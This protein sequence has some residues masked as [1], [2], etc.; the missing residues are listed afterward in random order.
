MSIDYKKI[1]EL[2]LGTPLDTDVIP[3]VDLVEGKTKKATKAELKGDKGDQGDQGI[4][5]VQGIQGIQGVKGDIGITWQGAWSAGTYQINDGVSHNGSS[6]IATSITTEEPSLSATDWDLV[7]QRGDDGTGTGDVSSNTASSVDGEIALFSGVTG[8]EIKRAT[9]SGVATIT[10]GVLGTKTNP[11]GAFV[12]TTDTQTLEN[13]TLTS[14][15]INT[16][17]GIVKGDVGLGNVDNTSDATKNSATAT[18]TNKTITDS[19]NNVTANGLRTATTTVSVSGATAPTAGQVLTATNGT[20]ATWQTPSGGGGEKMR[21][22]HSTTQSGETSATKMA[23]DT[24]SYDTGNNFAS[25]TYTVPTSGYYRINVR[26]NFE[27]STSTAN[28]QYT[29]ELRVNNTPVAVGYTIISATSR[30]STIGINELLNLTAT[31][32]VDVYYFGGNVNF[33]ILGGAT[34]TMLQI[35]QE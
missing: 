3:Y 8:K 24:E 9:G 35:S 28:I 34:Q 33:T 25:N 2:E 21:A 26:A 4:Q 30:S 15:V 7:A 13:K 16:P 31:D 29:L 18:L 1:S 11:T 10:S 27:Q 17:T 14:P 23:F 12:G 5:G 20:T 22:Y 6:W 32:T 19:T